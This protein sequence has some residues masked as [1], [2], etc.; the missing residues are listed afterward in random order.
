M[1]PQQLVYVHGA[2]PQKAASVLK[3]ELDV[4]LSGTDKSTT[5]VAQYRNVRWPPTGSGSTITAAGFGR[6]R[7]PQAIRPS[8]RP[9]P[10]LF[11][12][13]RFPGTG[14]S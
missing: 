13:L 7:R 14:P 6:A 9:H 10:E 4:L 2:G 1:P 5:R 11:K 3:H 8:D 12:E